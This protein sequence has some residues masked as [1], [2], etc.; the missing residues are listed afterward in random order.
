MHKKLGGPSL[1]ALVAMAGAGM[2]GAAELPAP[3]DHDAR[4][5]YIDYVADQVTVVTVRR[6]AVTRIVL[7]ENEHIAVAASGFGADCAKAETEWCVRAD[8]GTSQVWIKPKVNATENNLELKTDKHDYSFEFR[9]L[10][11]TRRTNGT[12]PMFRVI[13]RYPEDAVRT[14]AALA[15][16]MAAPDPAIDFAA[17]EKQLLDDRLLADRP[18]PRNWRYSMQVLPASGDIAPSLVFDDG[19]FTYFRFAG[20]HEI[21]TIFYISPAGEEARVNFHMD[22]DLA[23]VQRMGKQFVLR[24]GAQTVGIWNDAFDA[25]GVPPKEGTLVEGVTR[26]ISSGH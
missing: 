11:D 4:V 15:S 9:V 14:N 20:N 1:C 23:V 6:G 25:E 3:S 16:A 26:T 22:G 18:V 21:P 17:K 13:F 7:G 24:L 19:H 2:S 12:D 10:P 5:R 8:V